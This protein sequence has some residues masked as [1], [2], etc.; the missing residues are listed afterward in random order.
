MVT[1]NDNR[2]QWIVTNNSNRRI[3]I[4]DLPRVPTIQPGQGLNL[5]QYVTKQEIGQSK[6]LLAAINVGYVV[7]NKKTEEE[8]D[9]IST[10]DA[11][12]AITSA[13]ENELVNTVIEGE[14]IANDTEGVL[15]FGKDS[16]N[17]AQPIKFSGVNNDELKITTFNTDVILEDI[18]TELIKANIYMSLMTGYEI[19]NKEIN[20]KSEI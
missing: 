13:E 4:G 11:G 15:I 7:L 19:R 10:E 6:G 2:E 1:E 8:D 20:L 9:V 5:L 16:D 17:L 14:I 12:D 3:S 18:L